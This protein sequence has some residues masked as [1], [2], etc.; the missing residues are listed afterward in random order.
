MEEKMT[1]E[2]V[3]SFL[4]K[5]FANQEIINI[6]RTDWVND[7]D[8][9]IR[10]ENSEYDGWV[11]DFANGFSLKVY[12]IDNPHKILNAETLVY[13]SV[14]KTSVQFK[15][16]KANPDGG[17]TLHGF[18]SLTPYLCVLERNIIERVKKA[19]QD[20]ADKERVKTYPIETKV[21]NDRVKELMKAYDI[22]D[23]TNG[24]SQIDISDVDTLFAEA[25]FKDSEIL[26]VR[27]DRNHMRDAWDIFFDN[28]YVLNCYIR[29]MCLG[30][31]HAPEARDEI[32]DYVSFREIYPINKAGEALK[33]QC[34]FRDY[35]QWNNKLAHR[36]IESVC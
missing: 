12:V 10:T 23:F 22:Q 28:G 8:I 30:R 24:R 2:V 29:K 26:A 6:S 36:V 16:L 15:S 5:H 11:V 21:C 3:E 19:K 7:S 31:D 33:L 9:G 4:R 18:V 14:W 27:E 1:N 34:A 20:E 17:M 13:D 25:L 35:T 32:Y